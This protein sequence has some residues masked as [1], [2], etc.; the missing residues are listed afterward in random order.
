[1]VSGP[2]HGHYVS[3]IKTMGTWFIFDDET[4]DS[5]KE[6]DIPKYF[7]DSNSG[8]AY[9]L[10]YQALDIDFSA[11]GL[12]PPSPEPVMQPVS[13]SEQPQLWQATDSPVSTALSLP[14]GLNDPPVP[15]VHPRPTTPPR[16]IQSP[17]EPPGK[18]PPRRIPSQFLKDT[19]TRTSTIGY[20]PL[21]SDTGRLRNSR[22]VLDGK[23]SSVPKPNLSPITILP[24]DDLKPL[25]GSVDA[26]NG[27]ERDSDKSKMDWL[28]WP[29]KTVKS[30]P[31]SE[32]NADRPSLPQ[33]VLA[34]PGSPVRNQSTSSSSNSSKDSRHPLDSP[35]SGHRLPRVS[36]LPNGKPP[37]HSRATDTSSHETDLR[38]SLAS[39]SSNTNTTTPT[40][41]PP[42]RRSQPRPLP[43]I[44]QA[45]KAE[46][47]PPAFAKASLD[48]TRPWRHP[49]PSIKEL[50]SPQLVKSPVRPATSAGGATQTPSA[51]LP[52]SS[53]PAPSSSAITSR[54]DLGDDAVVGRPKSAHA[55]SSHGFLMSSSG[56]AIPPVPAVSATSTTGKRTMRKLSLSAP[57]HVFK[58][59]DKDQ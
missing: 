43:H 11:L 35:T 52:S 32:L 47:Q 4:V 16:T 5:I 12:R 38:H 53:S 55:S 20:R 7:G 37:P 40:S 59:R 13:Q 56:T 58:R 51:P 8:S 18:S 14:P 30:R 10:Y 19:L 39:A 48:H 45:F 27:K 17:L 26:V 3:I 50:N 29:F 33:D 41:P 57:M 54:L 25:Q 1:M 23:F 22:S 28:R 44:P 2:N 9:V 42:E 46:T 49:R 21:P 34:A 24:K 6:S 36:T 31:S 15:E